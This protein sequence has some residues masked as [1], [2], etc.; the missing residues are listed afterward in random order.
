MNVNSMDGCVDALFKNFEALAMD[1]SEKEII[2]LPPS[3]DI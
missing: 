2:F 1:A 3:S